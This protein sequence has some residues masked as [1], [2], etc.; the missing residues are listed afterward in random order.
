MNKSGFFC[1]M[2]QLLSLDSHSG[3]IE[4][5]VKFPEHFCP[6]LLRQ[7]A[8]RMER[9]TRCFVERGKKSHDD[10]STSSCLGSQRVA[11]CWENKFNQSMTKAILISVM[12]VQKT[13]KPSPM[14]VKLLRRRG[15]LKKKNRKK[16]MS[17][18]SPFYSYY[19]NLYRQ[20]H[21]S[22]RHFHNFQDGTV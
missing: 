16:P 2:C 10:K 11:S 20:I 19:S 14:F 9:L 12:S 13:M 21:R 6:G 3:V 5:Q 7:I 18:F 8:E 22:W 15:N 4:M 17:I 1:I